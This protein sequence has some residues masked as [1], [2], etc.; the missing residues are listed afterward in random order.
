MFRFV[1][2]RALDVLAPLVLCALYRVVLTPAAANV[3]PLSHVLVDTCGYMW[4]HG[5]TWGYMWIYGY[6]YICRHIYIDI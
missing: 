4:I 2:V 1:N 5:D 3:K 6:I